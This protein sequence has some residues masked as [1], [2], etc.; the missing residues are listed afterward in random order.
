MNLRTRISYFCWAARRYPFSNNTCPSCNSS[1]TCPVKRKA[2]VTVLRECQSCYLRFRVPKDD[3]SYAEAFYQT[4]YAQGSTT[5]CP[6]TSE[7][8][9]LLDSNF[10]D[11][12]NDFSVYLSVLRTLGMKPGDVVMDFGA[13]WGYGSWQ[14]TQ[15][16]CEVYSYEVSRPRAQY[17][18]KHLQCQTL[19]SPDR[20]PEK[21]DYFFSA[22][23]IEHLADPNVLWRAARAT[24]KPTGKIVLFM[25]NG[26][27]G[28]EQTCGW[29]HNLWGKVH[30][31]LLTARALEVMAAQNGFSGHAFTS[32]YDCDAI[33]LRSSGPL[34]GEEL[35]FISTFI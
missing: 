25:P 1:I 17:A 28:L 32:P 8:R 9:R 16:G 21:V 33:A 3:P 23:V 30:P 19:T 4:E 2:V 20:C 22:H 24:L 10:K 18:E 14:L 12:P 26:E 31:L 5:E 11:S 29:Y 6:S 7:L 27:P 13:S 35:L 15:S 34:T